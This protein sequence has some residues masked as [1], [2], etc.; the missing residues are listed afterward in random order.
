QSILSI[1]FFFPATFPALIS[2]LSLHA[3]LP[4][5]VV[6]AQS[7]ATALFH[8]TVG[9]QDVISRPAAH[10]DHQRAKIFLML[11]EHDL[12]G[13]KPAENRS[14]EHT[15]ELQSRFDIVCRLLL[16]KKNKIREI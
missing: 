14:E 11:G 5:Y 2:P 16:E 12:R 3:P 6:A 7:H 1:S 9:V 10:I 4:I 15:S 8:R 13:S